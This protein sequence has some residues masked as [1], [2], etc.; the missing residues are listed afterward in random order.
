MKVFIGSLIT[1]F[2]DER[3]AIKRAIEVFGH[4]AMMAEE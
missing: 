2:E 1:G 4:Q 3:V